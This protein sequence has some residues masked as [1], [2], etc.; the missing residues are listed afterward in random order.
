MIL[1]TLGMKGQ[2]MSIPKDQ[3]GFDSAVRKLADQINAKRQKEILQIYSGKNEFDEYIGYAREHKVFEKGNKSKSMRKIAT[4]PVEV[5]QFFTKV[6]GSSYYK[7][8]NFFT[9]HHPE[10]RVV[11]HV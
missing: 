1:L 10:W 11:G 4:F 5:D 6:Y 2:S 9:K 8:P 7:D 3:S